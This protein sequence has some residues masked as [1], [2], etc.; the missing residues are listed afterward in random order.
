MTGAA[1]G[2]RRSR[3]VINNPLMRCARESLIGAA[4]RAFSFSQYPCCWTADRSIIRVLDAR[5][6]ERTFKRLAGMSDVL[7]FCAAV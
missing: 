2:R 6:V 1:V 5:I 4:T 3:H 7:A